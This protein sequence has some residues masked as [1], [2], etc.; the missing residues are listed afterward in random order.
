MSTMERAQRIAGLL[1]EINEARADIEKLQE[2]IKQ[3]CDEI[4]SEL[5][6]VAP[7]FPSTTEAFDYV[8]K[9]IPGE[10]ASSEALRVTESLFNSQELRRQREERGKR[11]CSR[12]GE[13]H[14][15]GLHTRGNR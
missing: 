6:S 12:C 7:L 3:D 4:A 13:R 1:R 14:A 9:H 8:V 2:G 5:S 15:P 11:W 10:G